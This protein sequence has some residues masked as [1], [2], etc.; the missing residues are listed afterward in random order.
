MRVAKG[1]AVAGEVLECAKHAGLCEP[2]HE[3]AGIG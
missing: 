1:V 2:V 3:G